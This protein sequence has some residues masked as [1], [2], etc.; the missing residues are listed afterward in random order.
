M[1]IFN[2]F[3]VIPQLVAATVLGLLLRALF[4]GAP[5]YALVM[6]GVS[7]VL[8][9]ALVLRVPQAPAAPAAGALGAVGTERARAT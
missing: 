1:G 3:I 8:A 7:L 9:G 2:F 5:I 4:G 6:G